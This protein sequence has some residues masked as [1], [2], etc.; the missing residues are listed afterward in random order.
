MTR[1]HVLRDI[2]LRFRL[3]LLPIY[4]ALALL[5]LLAAC[6]PIGDDDEDDEPTVGPTQAASPAASPVRGPVQSPE[7]T[8]GTPRSAGTG[9]DADE[10]PTVRATQT[11]RPRP[12]PDD[13]TPAADEMPTPPTV[14]GC[15]EPEELP[16]VQ[17]DSERQTALDAD[18]GV[19]LRSAPG[20]D[21]DVLVTLAAGTPL[22]VESGPVR[23]G[24]FLWVKVTVEGTEGWVAEEFLE[25]VEDEEA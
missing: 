12:T 21:C 5:T 10:T 15:E 23:S 19:N 25:P 9:S 3:P 8:P 13:E 18:E 16:P 11:A 1:V 4:L 22:Q 24:D 2:A 7:G 6:G 20:A 17:G 14:E